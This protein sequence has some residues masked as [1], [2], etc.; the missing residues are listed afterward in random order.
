MLPASNDFLA[1]AMAP[2]AHVSTY[3]TAGDKSYVATLA[4]WPDAVRAA[5]RGIRVPTG[6]GNR[7]AAV[8]RHDADAVAICYF[9][10]HGGGTHWPAP[11]PQQALLHQEVAQ[12]AGDPRFTVQQGSQMALIRLRG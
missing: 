7:I 4:R 10:M 3:N 12:L 8:L 2:A 5:V 11:D 9:S 6:Q 1:L